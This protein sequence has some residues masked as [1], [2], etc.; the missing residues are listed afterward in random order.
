M[1]FWEKLLSCV[2]E[3]VWCFAVMVRDEYVFSF[4]SVLRASLTLFP[5]HAVGRTELPLL[6]SAHLPAL[7]S[8]LRIVI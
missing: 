6:L 7:K 5:S 4:S 2:G 1:S 8:Q 3:F